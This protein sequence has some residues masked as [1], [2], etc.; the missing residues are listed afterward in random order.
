MHF[1]VYSNPIEPENPKSKKNFK[2]HLAKENTIPPLGEDLAVPLR[3]QT[4]AKGLKANSQIPTGSSGQNQRKSRLS[5]KNDPQAEKDPSDTLDSD[6]SCSSGDG[7]SLG[8]FC[9]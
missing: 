9:L 1:V 7:D 3:P 4:R 2:T 6:S 5:K 8:V